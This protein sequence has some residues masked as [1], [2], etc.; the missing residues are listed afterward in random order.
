MARNV[1]NPY[2]ASVNAASGTIIWY[3][4]MPEVRSATISLSAE[5]RPTASSTASKSAIGTVTSRNVGKMY[6]KSLPISTIGTPR[7]TTS[8]TSFSIRA[9]SRM[10]VKTP[11]P[12]RKG[13]ATSRRKYRRS[14]GPMVERDTYRLIIEL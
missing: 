8:S 7:L 14:V 13:T 12:K 4:L 2:T 1:F 10:K 11:I 6:A 3:K 9:M 5:R